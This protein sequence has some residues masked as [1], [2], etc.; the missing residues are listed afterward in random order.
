MYRGTPSPFLS[1]LWSEKLR[2]LV[3]SLVVVVLLIFLPTKTTQPSVF[4]ACFEEEEGGLKHEKTYILEDLFNSINT[5]SI[6]P[7]YQFSSESAEAKIHCPT[8]L[9]SIDYSPYEYMDNG[10]IL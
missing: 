8:V 10:L 2:C 9:L 3:S 5:K 7:N 6:S 4:I 1:L